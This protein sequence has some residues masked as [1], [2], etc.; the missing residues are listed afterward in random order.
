MFAGIFNIYINIY[1]KNSS[2]AGATVEFRPLSFCPTC[3][4]SNVDTN[5]PLKVL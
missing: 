5:T 1:S 3:S 2:G 4:L